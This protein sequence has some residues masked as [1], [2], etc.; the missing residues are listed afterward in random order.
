MPGDGEIDGDEDGDDLTQVEQTRKR[1]MV[2]KM[3]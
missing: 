1:N 3:Q 2:K